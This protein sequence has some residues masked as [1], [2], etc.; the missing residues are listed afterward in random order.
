MKKLIFLCLTTLIFIFSTVYAAD[1]S[2]TID[3]RELDMETSPI[4][5]GGRVL[6]PIRS[7]FESLGAT[8]EWNSDTNTAVAGL[9]GGEFVITTSQTPI[10]AGQQIRLSDS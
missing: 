8:V 10:S 6:M 1:I 3:G 5:D 7:T 2:V 9:T 4:V